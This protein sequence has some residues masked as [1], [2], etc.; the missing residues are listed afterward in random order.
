[1]RIHH[2]CFN[3]PSGHK[4]KQ[5][6]RRTFTDRNPC[7]H[8]YMP[9]KKQVCMHT[10]MHTYIYTYENT[11]IHKDIACMQAYIHPY[12][13]THVQTYTYNYN[14]TYINACM[15]TY[16]HTYIHECITY[17]CIVKDLCYLKYF[18][19]SGHDKHNMTNITRVLQSLR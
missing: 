19:S 7:M 4:H 6:C 16:I 5:T 15:H 12:I 13:H 9:T 18:S 2:L 14:H 1:M 8:A 11:Y 3:V 17:I 10:Y